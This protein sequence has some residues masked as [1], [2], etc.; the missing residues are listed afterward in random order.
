MF[1]LRALY[2]CG[3]PETW[4]LKIH[5]HLKYTG[6]FKHSGEGAM[7]SGEVVF[8]W[9]FAGKEETFLKVIALD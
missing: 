7:R 5:K 8:F 3:R 9:G 6:C 2:L 1:Y 4:A